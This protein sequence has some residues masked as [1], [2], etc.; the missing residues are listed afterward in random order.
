MLGALPDS[1]T[2]L[3][4]SRNKVG[5]RQL[6]TAFAG[7]DFEIRSITLA[8]VELRSSG[9]V[10]LTHGLLV[11]S[12]PSQWLTSL[13][14]ERNGISEVGCVAL[15]FLLEVRRD[16]IWCHVMRSSSASCSKCAT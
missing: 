9:V 6:R 11:H 7:R 16:A 1:L 13:D 3:D 2:A 8:E 15:G 12:G 4:L 5:G 10:E 14:L